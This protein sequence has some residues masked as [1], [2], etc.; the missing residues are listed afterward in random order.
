MASKIKNGFTLL[1]VMVALV[2]LAMVVLAT[3]QI[4]Q[5]SIRAKSASDDALAELNQLDTL[6]R[7]MQ[8]DFSQMSARKVR[9]DSGDTLPYA[10]IHGRYEFNSEYD[11]IAFVRDGWTNPMLLLPRSELQAVGYRVVDE[12]LERVYRVYVDALDDTEPRV[13]PLLPDVEDLRFEFLD[14][15]DTWQDSWQRRALPKAVAV[16]IT[17]ED[18]APLKRLFLVPG[19][20]AADEDD[21]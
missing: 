6:F 3:H 7:L 8:Q 11:G 12:Q 20:G 5:S 16:I 13:Q 1:E 2:V 21:A 14:D 4:L 10:L 9:N 18:A 17:Q 19:T 15:Q